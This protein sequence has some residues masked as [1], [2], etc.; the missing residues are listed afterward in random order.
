MADDNRATIILDGEVSP[1]KR[2]FFE[3]KRLLGDFGK[4]GAESV[5][6]VLEPMNLLQQSFTRAGGLLAGGA[7]GAGMVQLVLSA[8]EAQDKLNDLSKATG[9]SVEDLS[10]LAHAAKLSGTELDS[11]AKSVNKLSVE[12]GKDPAK[13]R[14]LGITAKEPI[15]AF[16]Q[17]ADVLVSIEDIQL[18]NA[19]AQK[20]LGKSWEE[21]MPLLLEGGQRIG[22]MT[23]KGKSLSGVTKESA[24]AADQLNDSL[25]ELRATA[26]GVGVT[27][28]NPLIARLNELIAKLQDATRAAGS[29][30]KGFATWATTSG[31]DEA[32]PEA[33]YSRNAEK[34]AKLREQRQALSKDTLGARLNR[35][36]SP[37]D[38]KI[39][40]AQIATLEAQQAYLEE[41][42]ARR[43]ESSESQDSGVESIGKTP[44]TKSL[45]AFVDEDGKKKE[46]KSDDSVMPYYEAALASEKALAAERDAMRE[47]SKAQELDFWRTIQQNAVMSEKDR[48]AVERK[49]AQLTVEVKRQAAQQAQQIDA[50]NLRSAQELALGRIDAEQAA[51]EALIEAGQI[52]QQQALALEQQYEQQ[53]YAIRL[54]ALQERMKLLEQDPEANAVEMTKI[55]NQLLELE[56]LYQVKKNQLQGKFLQLQKVQL[57]KDKAIWTDFGQSVSSL[58]D[59]GV[60][61]MMNG[62]LKWRNAFR[63][64][65]MELV[66]WFA[67]SV[68]G[69][70]LKEWIGGE[71]AKFAVS[72]GWIG[73]ELAVRLGLIDEE[74]AAQLGGTGKVIGAKI[75]E[76]TTVST[77]N[78]V[79]AGT[80]AAASQA[81]IPIVGPLLA[82]AAMGAIFAAVSAMSGKLRSASRGFNIP[83]GLNPVT[84]LHE[85]EMVL[86]ADIANPLRDSLIGGDN[87]RAPVINLNF[88][89]TYHDRA[90]I[91]KLLLDNYAGV[92]DALHKATRQFH[93]PRK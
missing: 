88:N 74:T 81:P 54:A 55:K 1:L 7:L 21:V 45:R 23:A 58:W 6:G 30:F 41:L 59:K 77:A 78:A 38:L 42:M 86:P 52:T 92:A 66:G 18:R 40:D 14:T 73:K 8:A 32:D 93:I 2:A 65:G 31:A 33:A 56:Q 20:A 4:E 85:E 27:L 50:E 71:A 48:I 75:T 72:Q 25:E 46:K 19:V 79:E 9:I 16:K 80:G 13:F 47:Y 69:R 83:S 35:F 39:V 28:A 34:L 10:G 63:A 43:K 15:E 68:V 49:V 67:N 60:T 57:E 82:I 37:E 76:A 5:K 12:M 26:N 89:A 44:S 24:E 22:E 62:T 87:R 84:Q 91:R 70:M 17:L 36:F 90:G 61:A 64:I 51:T 11:V 29:F 3:A 53:R